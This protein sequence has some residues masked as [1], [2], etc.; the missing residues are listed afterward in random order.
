MSKKK[1]KFKKSKKQ[2]A[3]N[4]TSSQ[5][6]NIANPDCEPIIERESRETV[7]AKTE[8]PDVYQTDEY[9]HVKKDI[10]K[11]LIIMLIIV[12]VLIG[13]YLLSLKTS[14][15][16]NFGNWTYKLLNIQTL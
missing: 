5:S 13:I 8:A 2:Q 16:T 1:N 9:A 7:Q 15:L 10:R 12:I 3:D 6:I 4:I 11:I 14:F